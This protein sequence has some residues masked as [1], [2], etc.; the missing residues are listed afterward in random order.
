M[1]MVLDS[2]T[3]LW[4]DTVVIST[5]EYEALTALESHIRRMAAKRTPINRQVL[6]RMLERVRSSRG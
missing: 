2:Y 3:D 1:A 6:S 5:V 4:D